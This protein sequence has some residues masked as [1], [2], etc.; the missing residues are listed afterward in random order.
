MVSEKEISNQFKGKKILVTGGSGSVGQAIVEK[1]LEY[2][3]KAIRIL[4]NDENSIFEIKR[5]FDKNPLLTFMIGDVRDLDRVKLAIRGIDIV[6]HAAAM[7]H[8]DICE[9]NPFDAIKTN[10][11]GTS[12]IIEASLLENIS[13]FVF[14]S[15]DK[16]TNP[17]TTLGASKLLGER[18]THDATNYRGT[19]KTIFTIVR[20]GNVLGSRGSVFQIF[21][22]QLKRN[23]PLTIT[24]ERMTRFVMSLPDAASLI[25]KATVIAKDGEI[26]ILKM[27]SV[28]IIDLAKTMIKV[29]NKKFGTHNGQIRI[30]KIREK[31]K[32]NEILLNPYELN[33]CHDLGSIFKISKNHTQNKMNSNQMNSG[34]A[35]LI[36]EKNL[37][38]IIEKLMNEF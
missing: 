18:L 33:Y 21:Y 11:I 31:E 38:M 36:S 24:D 14:I 12:N 34:T 3:P 8:I 22:D 6:F 17:S 4:T 35:E 20:F 13:K 37:I 19:G 5:I 25:L 10:V 27:N 28:K 32:L 7:K 26:F 16:A 30:G 9:A 1:L 15:T 2:K 23:K 29:F